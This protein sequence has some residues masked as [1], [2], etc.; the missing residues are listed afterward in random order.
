MKRRVALW[1]A[2][3][4]LVMTALTGHTADMRLVCAEETESSSSAAGDLTLAYRYGAAQVIQYNT[5]LPSDTELEKFSLTDNHCNVVESGAQNAT[6]VSMYNV[7]GTIVLGFKF[8]K[9]FEKD[10]H[11]RLAKGSVFVFNGGKSSYKLTESIELVFDGSGWEKSASAE[12]EETE[13]KKLSLECRTWGTGEVLQVNTNLPI[14]T[15]TNKYY[16]FTPATS[17]YQIDFGTS[18][19]QFGWAGFDEAG[20]TVVITFHFNTAMETGQRL[21]LKKDSVFAFGVKDGTAYAG[22]TKYVLDKDYAFVYSGKESWSLEAENLTL[23]YRWGT[24]NILQYNTNLPSDTEQK[25]FELTE[26]NCNVTES[27]AQQVSWIGMDKTEGTIVLSFRFDNDYQK[28]EIYKLEA[29]SVFGFN[30]G[31]SLYVLKEDI[32]LTFDGNQW[33][34]SVPVQE[35]S[36]RLTYRSGNDEYIQYF[37]DLPSDIEVK[38]FAA[39]DNQSNLAESGTQKAEWIGMTDLNGKILLTVHFDARAEKNGEYKLIKGSVFGFDEG[40]ALYVL[41]EDI[42]LVFDGDSW[43]IPG[44][45]KPVHVHSYVKKLVKAGITQPGSITEICACGQIKQTQI[46]AAVSEIRIN[47]TSMTYNGKQQTVGLT[48]KDSTGK[49]LDASQYTVTGTRSAKK[50]GNYQLSVTLKGNYTG[51]KILKWKINPKKAKITSVTAGRKCLTVK[52]QKQTAETDGYQIQVSTDKKF[53]K[54]VKTVTVKKNQT[55]SKKIKGLKKNKKYYVR[56]R[57]YKAGNVSSWTVGQKSIKVR[58]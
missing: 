17:G 19:R 14:Q 56:M 10:E 46:I 13:S 42:D 1:M 47:K 4:L 30:G 43:Q 39:T 28:G 55:T 45:E 49:V 9:A 29:G 31:K 3:V 58:S 18:D 37:T 57:T 23:E 52:W 16:N 50:V 38:S 2:A 44:S 34:E 24:A 15:E 8:A 25:R 7:E 35:N 22:Q 41:A 6:S 27:G 12:P 36:L 40:K 33:S 26:N 32:V 54:N 51:K 48:V 5:N 53:K 21:I 11:Y 20:G